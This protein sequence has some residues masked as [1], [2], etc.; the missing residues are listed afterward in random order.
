M[1]LGLAWASPALAADP[2]R[3]PVFDGA[4]PLPEL[5]LGH[6]RTQGVRVVPIIGE[7]R[8]QTDVMS[9]ARVERAGDV[10][11]LIDQP[12]AIEI[13]SSHG[14]TLNVS[15]VAARTTPAATVR[16][17]RGADGG[18]TAEPWESGVPVPRDFDGDGRLGMPVDVSASLCSGHLDVNTFA[19]A[20]ARGALDGAL[21]GDVTVLVQRDILRASNA[22]LGLLSRHTTERVQGQFRFVP[23]PPGATCETVARSAFPEP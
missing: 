3:A 19:R 8:T 5:W 6:Q 15:A 17:T 1:I 16:W 4:A 14:V 12:C 10:L 18:W 9:I 2:V 7:I 20:E 22:C 23:A 11:V 13:G 21:S